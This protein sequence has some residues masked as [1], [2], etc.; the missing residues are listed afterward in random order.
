MKKTEVSVGN[1]YVALVSGKYAPVQIVATHVG[2]GWWG[3]N[4]TTGRN[5]RIRTAG[6]LRR[7][8]ACDE[9]SHWLTSGATD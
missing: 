3:T 4:L 6:R 1:V 8:L 2:G 7:Q 9:I 5:I